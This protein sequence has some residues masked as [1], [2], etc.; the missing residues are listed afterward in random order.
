[1]FQTCLGYTP[2][3]E[4]HKLSDKVPIKSQGQKSSAVTQSGPLSLE[5]FILSLNKLYRFAQ[6]LLSMKFILWL[7]ETRTSVSPPLL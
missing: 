6:S 4:F 2:C 3:V 7:R 1:M 5:S